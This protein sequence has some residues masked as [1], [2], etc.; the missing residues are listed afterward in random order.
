VFDTL[1]VRIRATSRGQRKREN[2][3]WDF[4]VST[5]FLFLRGFGKLPDI[6]YPAIYPCFFI[7]LWYCYRACKRGVPDVSTR[8]NHMFHRRSSF[9]LAIAAVVLASMFGAQ[10]APGWS[11]CDAGF[12]SGHRA[13]HLASA[14]PHRASSLRAT[15]RLPAEAAFSAG[16][17]V[18]FSLGSS[19]GS[20]SWED[21]R[22]GPSRARH[23]AYPIKPRKDP[24]RLRPK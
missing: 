12:P 5:P 17:G 10:D 1:Q 24:R 13:H 2:G 23:S 3:C 7:H 20:S 4:A 14:R 18:T 19:R 15:W 8:R 6:G 16:F 11:L 22:Q 21:P 9:S